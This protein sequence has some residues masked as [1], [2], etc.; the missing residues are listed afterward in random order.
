[1]RKPARS[2]SSLFCPSTGGVFIKQVVRNLLDILECLRVDHKEVRLVSQLPVLPQHGRR[3]HQT[4]SKGTYLT[5]CRVLGLA[6]RKPASSASSLFSPSKGGVFIKQVVKEPTWHAVES[7]GWQWGSPPRQPAPCS[8]PAPAACSS[9][10]SRATCHTAAPPEKKWKN[11]PY[12]YIYIFF[13]ARLC[14]IG[15]NGVTNFI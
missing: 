9:V 6:V 12:I 4:G 1:M 7:W 8:A 11:V 5:C 15:I 14:C 3:V 10:G 2:A 13:W